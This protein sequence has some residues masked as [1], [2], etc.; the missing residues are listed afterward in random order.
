MNISEFAKAAGVSKSAVSRYFND[1]YL[2]GDKKKLI[3]EAIEKTGYMP[4]IYAQ[5]VKTKITKLVGVIIPKLSSESCARIT[6]GISEVL[7]EHGY[8]ILL[9]NT[10]NNPQKEVEFLELFRKNRVDGVIFLASIF[11]SQHKTV[12]K[13]MRIPVVIVGQQYKGFCC[14]CHDD[15]GAAYA[16]TELMIK[17]GRTRPAYI[18]VTNDDKAAGQERKEGF[19]KALEDNNIAVNEKHIKIAEFNMSSGY[20]K[21]SKILKKGNMPDCIFCAT[22]NIAAGAMLYCL[23]NSI[24]IPEDIMLASIG[25]SSICKT[26]AV[27]FTSARLHYK[28]AGA[29]AAEMLL[30]SLKKKASVPKIMK[31]DYEIIERN[32]TENIKYETI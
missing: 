11:T 4:S 8:Q 16:L 28:T 14:V 24:K 31:L 22:D 19:L 5:N 3:E 13:K 9:G 21:A 32:S 27:T 7:N 2:S 20:E 10:S 30:S 25:D 1:G 12:L 18:G 26:T 15:F 17:R 23:E 29:E 6:D